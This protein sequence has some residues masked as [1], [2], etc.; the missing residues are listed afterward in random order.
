MDNEEKILGIL[1]QLVSG[2]AKLEA[3][4]AK[5]EAGQVKLEAGQAKLEAGQ[6]KLEAGQEAMQS[7][8]N[9]LKAGQEIIQ[10]DIKDLKAGQESMRKEIFGLA[11]MLAD[12]HETIDRFHNEANGKL[13][14]LTNEINSIR[15]LTMR[16]VLDIA[17]LQEKVLEPVD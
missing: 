6:A 16:N 5:L 12:T 10:S 11:D 8:I 4:Q 17:R 1:E 15:R 13:D 9:N 7:D 14:H 2:Q 3:G